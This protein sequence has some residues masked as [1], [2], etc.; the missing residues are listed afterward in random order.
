MN[1]VSSLVVASVAG[2]LLGTV[3]YGGL[4]LTVRRGVSSGQPALWFFGSLLLRLG[5]ALGGFYVVSGGHWHRLLVCLMGFVMA[6]L[7]VTWLIRPSG[8]KHTRPARAASH[9]PHP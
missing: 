3:F 6:R 5:I 9:A 7:V 2:L 1:D 8:E 4:W